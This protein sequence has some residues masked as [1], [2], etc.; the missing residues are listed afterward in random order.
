MCC[1]TKG[2][3]IPKWPLCELILLLYKLLKWFGGSKLPQVVINNDV[4]WTYF[5][6]LFVPFTIKTLSISTLSLLYFVYEWFYLVCINNLI[7]HQPYTCHVC[8]RLVP[9]TN[10]SILAPYI[11]PCYSSLMYQLFR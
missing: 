10:A 11:G 3:K 8:P 7:M 9:N 4:Y 6:K 2:A 1:S 5:I